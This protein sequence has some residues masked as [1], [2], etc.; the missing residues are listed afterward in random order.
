MIFQ[1]KAFFHYQRSCHYALASRRFGTKQNSQSID[2]D[3]LDVA[4]K[5]SFER[6]SLEQVTLSLIVLHKGQIHPLR[7]RCGY[8]HQKTRTWSTA[9]SIAVTLI[10]MLV[11]QGKME[12][13]SPLG[14]EWL[15]K[16]QTSE[17]DPRR[18][19]L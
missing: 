9:K 12:L 7:G 14:I 17:N 4:S 10:G 3:L 5:W 13:D 16:E 19:H 11:D 6:E 18:Y 15:P 2:S 1:Y 8:V